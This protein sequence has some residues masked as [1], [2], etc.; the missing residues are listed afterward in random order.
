MAG[1]NISIE[2]AIEAQAASAAHMGSPLY[3][4]LLEG[5]LTDL[6]MGGIT[7]ELLEGVSD[8]PMRDA[9]PLR[10]LATAHRLALAGDAPGL[11]QF[12]PSCGGS[13]H[14]ENIAHEFVETAHQHRTE[15]TAGM[16]RNVQTNEVGR[17]PALASAFSL[18]SHR[19]GLPLDVFEI[20]SSAGLLSRWDQYHYDTGHARLGDP[21]SALRFDA[22]WW[23]APVPSLH[24]NVRIARRRGSDIAPIDASTRD[25]RLTMMSFVWPDHVERMARL[26]A[27]LD[28]AAQFP[29]TVEQADA[30]EWLTHHLASGPQSGTATVVFHSIV[31]QYLP[32]PTRD[33]V[34]GAL[35]AAAARAHQGAP[36][37]WVRME[38][39]TAAVAD[40]R[41]TSWPGGSEEVLAEVGYHGAD[42]R[43]LQRD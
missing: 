11:A 40:V 17:A 31:W 19:H 37:F 5:L 3:A 7:A 18:I 4:H 14:G 1:A 25:G 29:V 16:Q 6:R 10:Y 35:Y 42:I 38:P 8:Q 13:W 23:T 12:Y 39:A 20:G 32:K 26:R 9:I 30:G 2:Q 27:A 28:I 22:S 24:S 36:L 15:F 41:L 34:R 33:R 43:W 21:A